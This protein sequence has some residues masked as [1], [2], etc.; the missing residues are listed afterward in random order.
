MKEEI[1]KTHRFKRKT[2][3]KIT[4]EKFMTAS[5]RVPSDSNGR[6]TDNQF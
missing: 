1:R 4:S 6:S 3:A 2:A 5:A